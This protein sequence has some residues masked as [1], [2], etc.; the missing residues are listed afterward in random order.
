[1]NKKEENK[2]TDLDAYAHANSISFDQVIIQLDKLQILK[3]K[4]D[5]GQSAPNKK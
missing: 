2:T 1:M 5:E 4:K 3:G